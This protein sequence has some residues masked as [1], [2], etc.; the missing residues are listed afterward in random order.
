MLFGRY[1]D[2]L[3]ELEAFDAPQ[4]KVRVGNFPSKDQGVKFRAQTQSD[5]FKD[6]WVVPSPVIVPD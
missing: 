3:K 5:G 6:A 1:N 4:Y 2:L